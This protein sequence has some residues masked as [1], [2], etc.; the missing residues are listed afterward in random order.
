MNSYPIDMQEV[1]RGGRFHCITKCNTKSIWHSLILITSVR[2]TCRI[3]PALTL[4]AILRRVLGSRLTPLRIE[5]TESIQRW[6][7]GLQA[8]FPS[9]IS[10][11]TVQNDKNIA[12]II[13]RFGPFSFF[14]VA[15]QLTLQRKWNCHFV[16]GIKTWDFM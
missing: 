6:W 8:D 9:R 11:G 12:S 3:F 2:L 1:R 10:D 15:L 14:P 7:L 13:I 16:I 5:Q 4:S